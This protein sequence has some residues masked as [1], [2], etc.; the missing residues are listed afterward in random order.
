MIALTFMER[1][2]RI[3]AID[4][5]PKRSGKRCDGYQLYTDTIFFK[6]VGTIIPYEIL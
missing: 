6:E 4:H 5:T 1:C 2:V 3:D